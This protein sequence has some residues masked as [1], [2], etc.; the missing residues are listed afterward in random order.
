MATGW[1]PSALASLLWGA[2]VWGL[3]VGLPARAYHAMRHGGVEQVPAWERH[4]TTAVG[5]SLLL[6]FA[7]QTGG[8]LS[9][10]LIHPLAALALGVV[11]FAY[12]EYRLSGAA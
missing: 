4:L 12:P 6:V 5:G 8:R 1:L 2:V 11:L 7:A 3:V 10:S 9:E